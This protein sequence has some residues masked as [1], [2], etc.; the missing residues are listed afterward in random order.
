MYCMARLMFHFPH[1]R[2]QRP[3][4]HLHFAVTFILVDE[5]KTQNV[6]VLVTWT[7]IEL[8]IVSHMFSRSVA[9]KIPARLLGALTSGYDGKRSST[10]REHACKW[11][12]IHSSMMEPLKR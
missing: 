10:K 1:P 8:L 5:Q 12:M 4:A 9:G 3:L 6:D 11:K 2:L 7:K